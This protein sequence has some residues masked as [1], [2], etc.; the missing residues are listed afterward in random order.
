MG[1]SVLLG[2]RRNRV[3]LTAVYEDIRGALS[4]E[5]AFTISA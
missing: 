3:A 4:Y 2:H 5:A 1:L